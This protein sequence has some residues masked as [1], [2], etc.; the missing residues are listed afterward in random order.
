MVGKKPANGFR[1]GTALMQIG[2]DMLAMAA[3]NYGE[4][5]SLLP[6]FVNLTGPNR[7]GVSPYVE[8]G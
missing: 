5:M 2:N 7:M 1:V 4:T 3:V 6:L 8:A